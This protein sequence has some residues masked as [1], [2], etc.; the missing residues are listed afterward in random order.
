MSSIKQFIV[1][2]L[3]WHHML[4]VPG[5]DKADILVQV[6]SFQVSH[7]YKVTW[8]Q[9]KLGHAGFQSVLYLAQHYDIDIT[10]RKI[11]HEIKICLGCMSVP[12]K[13]WNACWS[14]VVQQTPYNTGRWTFQGLY[15]HNKHINVHSPLYTQQQDFSWSIHPAHAA[16]QNVFMQALEHLSA[17]Y[18][19]MVS[20]ASVQG[21]HVT[22]QT[23]Q[24]FGPK[25][26]LCP[27]S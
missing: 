17:A 25:T 3:N 14:H 21:S 4:L 5:N 20:V 23:V 7:M 19:C 1:Y 2:H 10:P 16:T 13:V 18:S 9:Q 27:D 12:R 22:S 15:L 6:H 11:I 26:W 24:V 8:L